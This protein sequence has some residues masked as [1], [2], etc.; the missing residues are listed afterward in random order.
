MKVFLKVLLVLAATLL[1]TYFL[2]PKPAD[3]KFDYTL[4]PLSIPLSA[5]DSI[6]A[7]KE[8]AFETKPNNE[9]RIIWADSSKKEKTKYCLLYLHGFSASATEA[10]PVHVRIAKKMGY[11][12]Y[13][14]RLQS[15]GLKDTLHTFEDLTAENYFSSAKEAFAIAKLLGEKVILLSTSTGGTLSLMLAAQYP[16]DVAA[17]VLLSPNIEIF[18]DNAKVLNDHWGAS[19]AKLIKGTDTLYS[20]RQDTLYKKYW[21]HRYSMQ[22][23]I[24]LESLIESSMTAETFKK[25]TTPTCLMYYY[26]NEEEQDKVV[27]VTAMKSMMEQIAS[28]KKEQYAIPNAGN[29]VI[30]SYIISKDYE[31]V[32]AKAISFLEKVLAK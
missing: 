23:A 24:A 3:P 9:S 14:P 6:L 25:V 11:N 4:K 29:H 16:N 15:H 22:G 10:D 13:L 30:G 21:N 1:V 8:K 12:L 20:S 31:N 5:L 19:I 18:D 32:A 26:K 7:V 27:K 2:G 28:V 17:Q